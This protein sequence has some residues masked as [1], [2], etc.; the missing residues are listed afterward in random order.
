MAYFNYP[1]AIPTLIPTD[2]NFR[3]TRVSTIYPTQTLGPY[4]TWK[5]PAKVATTANIVLEGLPTIDGITVSNG[6]R[7]LVK[8]Q[9]TASENGIY[10][11]ISSSDTTDNWLRAN[12]LPE[13]S[14]AASMAIFINEGT[15]NADIMFI[16]TND[17]GSDIV[18][19]NDLVYTTYGVTGGGGGVPG[20]SNTNV[21]YNNSGAFG[22][23]DTFRFTPT[24]IPSS[25]LFPYPTIGTI[26]LGSST[27]S[28]ASAALIT[29]VSGAAS[30][31]NAGKPIALSGGNGDGSGGGGGILIFGGATTTGTGGAAAVNGGAGGAG[32]QVSVSGGTGSVSTGGN[33][34]LTSG[35]G[36]TNGGTISLSA[37][38]GNTNGGSI[39]LSAGTGTS[40]NGGDINLASGIGSAAS[41]NIIITANQNGT[42]KG[43]VSITTSNINA[44]W[45]N[46][47]IQLTKDTGVG[48]T[49]ADLS[50]PPI[51]VITT[52]RQ[53]V[54]TITDPS[55]VAANA[56]ITIT[57]NNVN[58]LTNDT[59]YVCIQ[60]FNTGGT[61]IPMVLVSSITGTSFTIQLYNLSGA[62]AFSASEM[63]IAFQIL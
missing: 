41:G 63:K 31:G 57:V 6:D 37:G 23:S 28:P 24:L 56:S 58:I 18:G 5:L 29:A 7:I 40:T 25:S 32:G 20:G 49:I 1:F 12:D 2:T 21:Q 62:A 59:V 60:E 51:S 47:G 46:G 8:N 52:S 61:G 9:L 35:A 48:L 11:V 30:S 36:N 54:I 33:V 34:I 3:T 22:G 44:Y 39:I 26:T 19:S 13:G 4:T 38:T 15:A 55:A 14:S 10:V 45:L 17:I 43:Y 50:T 16:C 27:A 42:I 53:G